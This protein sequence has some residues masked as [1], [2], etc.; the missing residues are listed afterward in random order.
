MVW[1][2]DQ[3]AIRVK[4]G[5]L[6]VLLLFLEV[7]VQVKDLAETNWVQEIQVDSSME[8][9]PSSTKVVVMHRAIRIQMPQGY[10]KPLL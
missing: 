1:V 5:R 7:V 2:L 3:W 8:T 10:R 6:L 4:N 9:T